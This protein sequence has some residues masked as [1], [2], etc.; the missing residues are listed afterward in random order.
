MVVFLALVMAPVPVFLAAAATN[1]SFG[2][3]TARHVCGNLY[4]CF[5]A[6][7][8]RLDE[9]ITPDSLQAQAL[10]R[11]EYENCSFEDCNLAGADLSDMRFTD[12]VFNNCNLSLAE[13][14]NTCLRDVQFEGC[15]LMGLRFNTCNAFIL[16]FSAQACVLDHASFFNCK[17]KK[18]RFENCRLIETDFGQCDLTEAVFDGCDLSGAVFDNTLLEK[19]DFRNAHGYLINPET[20]RIKK[21]KFKVSGLAGLLQQ[22]QLHIEQG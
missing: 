3:T 18:T 4:F 21:A 8:Y 11:G 2:K 17:I 15:K 7:V 13:L 9:T 1:G 10:P 14:H 12:C 16:S 19:A 6:M 20:N 22:H 5:P